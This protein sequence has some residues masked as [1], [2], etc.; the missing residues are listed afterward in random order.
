MTPVAVAAI[1]VGGSWLQA[2]R[3]RPRGRDVL[4]KD[5]KILKQLPVESTARERLL[6]HIDK[7]I[8]DII[9]S[10]D[11]ETRRASGVVL[12]LTFL[13]IAV[14]LVVEAFILGGWWWTLI[15]P[16]SVIAVFGGVGLS[17]DAVPRKRNERGDA[18]REPKHDDSVKPNQ[19]Q[20]S[21]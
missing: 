8:L 19:A 15:I 17:Q 2:H 20:E 4:R 18:I 21:K 5:L 1:G 13:G 7:N 6:E 11:E 9:E 16:A 14:F 10:E 12:A 3:G